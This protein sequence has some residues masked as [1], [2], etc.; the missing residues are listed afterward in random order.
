[1]LYP[2]RKISAVNVQM[3]QLASSIWHYESGILAAES[4]ALKVFV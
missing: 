1:M 4:S 3:W 2:L